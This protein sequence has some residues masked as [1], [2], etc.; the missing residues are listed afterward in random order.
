VRSHCREGTDGIRIPGEIYVF[1]SA[2]KKSP[3]PNQEPLVLAFRAMR[4][5]ENRSVLEPK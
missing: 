3:H 1:Y 5:L 4:E 2:G